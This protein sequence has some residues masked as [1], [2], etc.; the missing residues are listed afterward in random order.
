MTGSSQ[1]IRK[2]VQRTDRK[3]RGDTEQRKCLHSRP[4]R[5]IPQLLGK[6]HRLRM[7]NRCLRGEKEDR[8]QKAH[9]RN[10]QHNHHVPNRR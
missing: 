5:H 9:N 3:Q 2:M 8:R 10:I 6:L 1:Y 7:E 4:F